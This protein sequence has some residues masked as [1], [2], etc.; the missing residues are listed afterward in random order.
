MVNAL[1]RWG[2][3][4]PWVHE[5]RGPASGAVERRFV[6]DCPVLLC[7]G[8]WFVV[9]AFGDDLRFG[10]EVLAV[11][12]SGIARRGVGHGW[13]AGEVD[14]DEDRAVATV[15]LPTT[16]AELSALQRLLYV[17]YSA[18]FPPGSVDPP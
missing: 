3:S 5:L 4:L 9:R 15:V 1:Y 13:A 18:A 14:P 17:A 12:P 8:L 7:T 16:A 6:I 2:G 10:P 11:L